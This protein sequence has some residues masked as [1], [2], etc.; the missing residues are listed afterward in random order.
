MK[1]L[2]AGIIAACFAATCLRAA[3]LST[4]VVPEADPIFSASSNQFYLA[5]NPAGY[6]TTTV[7]NG[8]PTD[9]LTNGLV[10]ASVT[11]GLQVAGAYVTAS[12]TNGL[13]T[14]TITNGL[15]GSVT[16]PGVSV[17]NGVASISTNGWALGGGGGSETTAPVSLTYAS[18]VSPNSADGLFRKMALTGN[19]V[20]NA[21]S[22]PSEGMKWEC[23]VSCDGTARTL[24]FGA[25]VLLPSDSALSLP[26]TL[27]INKLYIVLLKYNGTA[28][29]LA[30]IVGGY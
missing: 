30:S 6:V 8:L 27:T 14:T 4:G 29:M 10:T 23:W 1:R 2:I 13:A 12:V 18:T 7:T 5:S 26:K 17:T 15:I 16:G 25:G 21:P 20:I 11:N 24:N 28:W 9:A 3:S 19:V 22:N